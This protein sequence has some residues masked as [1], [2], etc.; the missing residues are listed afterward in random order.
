[1]LYEVTSFAQ[2][3]TKQTKNFSILLPITVCPAHQPPSTQSK[4][5]K[6]KQ[7]PPKNGNRK[8]A[9]QGLKKKQIKEI[10]QNSR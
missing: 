10:A 8:M 5:G 2:T 3:W 9:R 6:K 7:T 1:V 4:L